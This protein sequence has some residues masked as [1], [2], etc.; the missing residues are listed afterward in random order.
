MGDV[1]VE[2]ATAHQFIAA[3]SRLVFERGIVVDWAVC[4]PVKGA[5]HASA[6]IK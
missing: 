6:A 3:V 4:D 2:M 1:S 5:E